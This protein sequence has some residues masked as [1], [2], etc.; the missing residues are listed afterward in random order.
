MGR[1]ATQRETNIRASR[2]TRALALL[3]FLAATTMGPG[4]VDA[5]EYSSPIE[6]NDEDDIYQL[7][8][9]QIIEVDER[10]RLLDLLR[11]PVD[12]N[13]A[14]RDELYELPG[15]SY[16]LVDRILRYRR[17]HGDFSSPGQLRKVRGINEEIWSQIRPFTEA[18]APLAWLEDVSGRVR[19][20][21]NGTDTRNI[22][23]KLDTNANPDDPL[24]AFVQQADLKV[25]RDYELGWTFI[26]DRHLAPVSFVGW[27]GN[28]P[29]Y[30]VS[31][32]Q[33]YSPRLGNF[34]AYGTARFGSWDLI[35]GDYRV[36][37]GQGLTFNTTGRISPFGWRKNNSVYEE[38]QG[39]GY[40]M[41]KGQRG[42]AITGEGF[43]I[44][45]GLTA[46]VSAFVSYTD[47]DLYQQAGYYELD[48]PSEFTTYPVYQ[49]F[50]D[51]EGKNKLSHQ[52]L[53]DVYHELLSGGHV[54]LTLHDRHHIGVTGYGGRILWSHGDEVDFQMS[55]AAIFPEDR[56]SFGAFGVDIG[57]GLGPWSL[58]SEVAMTDAL[59][60][61]FY[62]RSLL[63]FDHVDIDLSARSYA[64]NYDNPH[65]SGKAALDEY[66]GNSDRD[67]RGARLLVSAKPPW[68]PWKLRFRGS[69]DLWQR[70]SIDQ[71]DC[72][73][74]TQKC[75]DAIVECQKAARECDSDDQDCES[76]SADC[77]YDVKEC[78]C[79]GDGDE[80]N[81]WKH[82]LGSVW[83]LKGHL[84]ASATPLRWLR[85]AL[86]LYHTD[87]D[88]GSGGR[89]QRYE[90]ANHYPARGQK[91]D[92]AAQAT[93]EPVEGLVFTAYYKRT[94][95]DV[96][97]YKDAFEPTQNLW[98]LGAWRF[99]KGWRV[100]TRFKLYDEDT[101][102]D[103]R[104]DRYWEVYGEVDA[105]LMERLSA[106][107]RYTYQE[108]DK[109]V[110]EDPNDTGTDHAYTDMPV[111]HHVKATLDF[112]F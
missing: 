108:M 101:L 98:F 96:S 110:Y 9:N 111:F 14:S 30:F 83:N 15:L 45:K 85:L 6:V 64:T 16:K 67:E 80:L 48:D 99:A 19:V 69:V 78:N 31:E 44:A 112:R 2:A 106:K 107:L 22:G 47:D 18:G 93:V 5:V 32:G 40:S 1:Q 94:L 27:E 59:S 65:A 84:R 79:S 8:E 36:G 23:D 53:P 39:T 41:P 29:G 11:E 88:L 102:D 95:K 24:P 61:A 87:M 89:E 68:L 100:A 20:R 13:E 3:A 77:R 17:K 75:E 57:T 7:Y 71:W 12:L 105:K 66:M 35:V 90:S 33:T 58:F 92:W 74:D 97:T 104:G 72:P 42:L 86:N 82:K 70:M 26:Q 52:T 34:K 109:T 62:V 4:R 49:V 51:D 76:D 43:R 60:S 103:T 54:R 37:Y 10:D 28:E 55:D 56:Q 63:E 91:T 81:K 25:M 21:A 73:I 38:Y 50:K 46:D